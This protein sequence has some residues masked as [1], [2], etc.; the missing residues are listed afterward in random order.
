[1]GV[2]EAGLGPQ[3]LMRGGVE[4]RV[5]YRELPWAVEGKDRLPERD[6]VDAVGPLLRYVGRGPLREDGKAE[7]GQQQGA[8]NAL[9]EPEI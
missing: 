1:L 3:R 7:A 2:V 5:A 4:R 6:V 8:E 9:G